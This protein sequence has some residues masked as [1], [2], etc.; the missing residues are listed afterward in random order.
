MPE[1]WNEFVEHGGP[2]FLQLF[3]PALVVSLLVMF[4]VRSL[5]GPR[6]TP[7]ASA[8]ALAAGILTANHF[9]DAMPLRFDDDRAFAWS[10][11]RKALGWSLEGRPAT[12]K[13]E[14]QEGDEQQE[15][16]LR[17][18]PSRYWLPWMAFFSAAVGLLCRLPF[19]PSRAVLVIWTV[20]ALFAARLLTPAFLRMDAPWLSWALGLVILLESA[21]LSELTRR[22]HDCTVAA[23]L[24]IC[25]GAAS[26]VLLQAHSARM[27]EMAMFFVPAF[28]SII[29][30]AWK[31]RGDIGGAVPAA[32]VFLPSVLLIGKQETF[33]EVPMSAFLL[34]A[35][36][37][38]ALAPMVL[39]ALLKLDG[40]KRWLPAIVLPA[41]PAAIAVILAMQVESA[42]A[43][44]E[45]EAATTQVWTMKSASSV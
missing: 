32:A 39:P 45:G 31:L 2:L 13:L 44:E 18:P 6:I 21:V 43:N 17:V 27:M 38:L 23:G 37:P 11:F 33:S 15:D 34:S 25:F 36:A 16:D 1:S 35:L 10:D 7:L 4:V 14:S 28:I 42:E 3:A 8:L 9:R 5:G 20:T 22:W 12:P 41:I 30:V 24:A 26:M 40:W 19:V 29:L